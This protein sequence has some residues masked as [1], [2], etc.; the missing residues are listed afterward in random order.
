MESTLT[1]KFVHTA[2]RRYA[3]AYGWEHAEDLRQEGRLDT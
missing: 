1:E 3:N 2:T